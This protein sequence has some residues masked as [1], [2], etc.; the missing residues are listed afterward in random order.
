[1]ARLKLDFPDETYTFST[2]LDVRF[3]DVN[4]GM[5]LAHD[6][7]V[8]FVAEARSRFLE[9]LQL[10][11]LGSA[12]EPGVI[13]SDLAVVYRAEGRLRDRLRVDCGIVDANRYG[14]DIVCRIVR[15]SDDTVIA[16]AKANVVFFDYA[17]R[18]GVTLAPQRFTAAAT[19]RA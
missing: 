16:V 4:A 1:M 15:E 3:D 13:V 9:H 17:H 12:D 6:R 2:R 14:G 7:V 18:K 5:H 8:S 11:E 10:C 19:P